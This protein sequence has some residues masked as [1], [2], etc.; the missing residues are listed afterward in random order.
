MTIND[1]S[2][3]TP[4]SQVNARIADVETARV[5]PMPDLDARDYG[6]FV[7]RA[8]ATENPSALGAIHNGTGSTA[9]PSR[10]NR[11]PPTRNRHRHSPKPMHLMPKPR[12]TFPI[13]IPRQRAS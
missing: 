2:P 10:S 13:S 11:Q 6:Q 7:F 8:E 3:A 4:Q 12:P 1:S 9:I 5:N